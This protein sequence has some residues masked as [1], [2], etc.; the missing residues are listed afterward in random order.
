MQLSDWSHTR[1][2][3][4]IVS[5]YLGIVPLILII[6]A[7]LSVAVEG[8]CTPRELGAGCTPG[9]RDWL[10]FGLLIFEL[11]LIVFVDYY[12]ERNAGNAI[13]ALKKMS[14]PVCR[15]RR[16]GEWVDAKVP[17]L[18]CGDIVE[19]VGGTVVPAD[20]RLLGPGEP[21]LMDESSLTG[22]ALA[23]TKFPG[24]DVLSGAVVEQ[25]ELEM[26]VTAT[27]ANSF[28]GKTIALIDSVQEQG[29]IQKVLG[30][31]SL[32]MVII[33][34]IGVTAIF[35]VMVFR[36]DANV[37]NAFK[38]AFVIL[39]SVVPLGAPVVITTCLAIGALELSREQAVVSRLSAIEEMAGMDVLCSD[40][41][42]TLTTNQLILDT[43]EIAVLADACDPEF[44]ILVAALAAK[45]ENQD[46][47]DT[48]ICGA[49]TE[50]GREDLEAHT[51]HRFVPFNPVDKRTEATVTLPG[52]ARWLY[53][54]GAPH[55]M[56][57]LVAVTEPDVAARADEV[58]LDKATRGLRALG[59]ARARLTAG[60]A[61]GEWEQGEWELLGM[62]SLLD[63]PRHDSGET[64]VRAA[65][66]G[67]EVKMITG[68][69]RAIGIETARRLNMGTDILGN[70]IW[71]EVQGDD[72]TFGG[73][74]LGEI[75]ES[76]NGFAGVYPEHKFKIVES[77]QKRGH[78]VGM[79]GDGVNDAPALKRANVGIAVADATD[80]AKGAAD[81][82][83]NAPGLSTIVS[84]MR[85]SRI[86]FRRLQE[87]IIYRMASSML[88]LIYFFFSIIVVE[89]DFPTW[90][91]ILLSLV[92]DLT[93]MATSLDRVHPN[94]A[95]DHWVM[96]KLLLI[97]LVLGGIFAVSALVLTYLSLES[98]VNWW[99]IWNLSTLT[100]Q[101]TVAVIYAHLGISIQLNIFSSRNPSFAL[102][103]SE[104]TSP[105]PS[106]Y[107]VV[108]VACALLLA[109]F[110]G[111]YWPGDVS[112]GGGVAM[113]G[114]GWGHIGVTWFYT[115]VWWFIVDIFKVGVWY[116]MSKDAHDMLFGLPL[117]KSNEAQ[118]KEE[119]KRV[120]AQ[121]RQAIYDAGGATAAERLAS[122]LRH[123][124]D[125]YMS[126]RVSV[127]GGT[128]GGAASPLMQMK[129]AADTGRSLPRPATATAGGLPVSGMAPA[130]A[131]GGVDAHGLHR[132]TTKL[133]RR[134]DALEASVAKMDERLTKTERAKKKQ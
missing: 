130:G 120:Q 81:I 53:S 101:Q 42:G 36:D 23:V 39:V 34:A 27:G 7:I 108:P 48:A 74:T 44:V 107:L 92:N 35:F 10:S 79:T 134:T 13:E 103:F 4:Q 72:A 17:D 47:I 109:T 67:V 22:E 20:G 68:D 117:Q 102:H 76:V 100:P 54:K 63:P 128:A 41:T 28:Y 3:S 105:P 112:L 113:A 86:I 55:I 2:F 25:G 116:A 88:I 50:K 24:D 85:Q 60:D 123:R 73:R 52:G 62:V 96:W 126:Q 82:L 19:L 11:N 15:C 56:R 111:V 16:D 78:F 70:E 58:I 29:N 118:A 18:V 26:V 40:K 119:L 46:A 8:T 43:D 1:G 98:Q 30:R 21:M 31:V 106:L 64:I 94:K 97:A 14:R 124:P 133:E 69:Q 33:G 131:A 32:M 95:P 37:G 57:D 91:L 51:V 65:E 93:V 104:R 5:R 12:G 49:L 122:E 121:N 59:V 99:H 71:S 77:L 84:A 45:Q 80:A 75:V 110:L 90:A 66:M 38:Q 6:T 127:A 115:V 61:E 125:G 89:F 83:L 132:R 114:A 129:A 87:Y 9:V